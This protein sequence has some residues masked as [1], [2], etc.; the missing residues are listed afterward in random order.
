[1]L[2][3]E[4]FPWG[5]TLATTRGVEQALEAMKPG[6]PGVEI[7]TAIFR[8]ATFI[9]DSIDN[10]S[11]ALLLGCVLVMGIIVVFLYEW[12]TAVP[13]HRHSAVAARGWLVLFEWRYI[14][15]MSCLA[16]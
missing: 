6:L 11:R 3:V 1:M 5:N 16:S 12:R 4:K 9:E 7:D 2:V 13:H 10:L 15:T 8:P 14:N